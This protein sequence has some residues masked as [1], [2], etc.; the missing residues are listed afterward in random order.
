MSLKDELIKKAAEKM[1]A[2]EKPAPQQ[3]SPGKSWKSLVYRLLAAALYFVV[4]S[5]FRF[6]TTGVF[7][8]IFFVIIGLYIFA[9]GPIDATGFVTWAVIIMVIFGGGGWLLVYSP[10]KSTITA[11]YN[12]ALSS[13]NKVA[14]ASQN[15]FSQMDCL[16]NPLLERCYKSG[17]T[18]VQKSRNGLELTSLSAEPSVMVGQIARVFAAVK[19][20]GDSN[21][22]VKKMRIIAGEGKDAKIIN[23]IDC[24]ECANGIVGEK[25]MPNSKRDLTSEITIPCQKISSYPFTLNMEYEYDASAAL[26]VDVMNSHDYNT[27]TANKDVF[28]AQPTVDSS[29]GPV[30]TSISVG[31]EGYQPLKGGTKN[32]VFARLTNLGTGS[33]K[34]NN[35][36]LSFA[37]FSLTNCKVN[38]DSTDPTKINDPSGRSYGNEKF[39]TIS[40]DTSVNNVEGTKRFVAT[41]EAS[42]LYN[43]NKTASADVDQSGFD[44]CNAATTTTIATTTTTS[45]PPTP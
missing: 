21:A 22:T 37:P 26:P 7:L 16:T 20:Q 6:W 38:G 40:C 45:V 44:A 32:I 39:I 17:T 43:V 41:V 31:I 23:K 1:Q 24:P 25:I 18:T 19:N 36:K 4:L 30:Q 28:L 12:N 35:A 9:Y 11:Y 33:F 29:S 5:L 14:E 34:L 3:Y 42:Y 27:K 2:N 15:F 13:V 8:I 10:W